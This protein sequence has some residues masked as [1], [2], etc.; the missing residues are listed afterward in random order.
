M[1][2]ASKALII[3]GAILISILLIGVGMFIYNA[4]QKPI[5]G[6]GDQMDEQ[7][8]RMFNQKFESY[9]G[10]QNGSNVKALI[11][12][13]ITS[14][15]TNKDSRVVSVNTKTSSGDLSDLRATVVNG[16]TY[17][18]KINYDTAGIVTAITFN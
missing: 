5:T 16:R 2:N 10:V 9:D 17:T 6:A 14:N 11:S 1:E 15:A 8:I 18:V 4:A 13:V 3:A 7:A 12:A